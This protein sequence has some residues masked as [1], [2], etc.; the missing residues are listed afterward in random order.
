MLIGLV[1]LGLLI[2]ILVVLLVMGE[3]LLLS[4]QVVVRSTILQSEKVYPFDVAS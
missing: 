3:E 2:K 4:Y 1:F